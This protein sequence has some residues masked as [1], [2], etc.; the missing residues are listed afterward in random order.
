MKKIMLVGPDGTKTYIDAEE[1]KSFSEED[2]LEYLTQYFDHINEEKLTLMI[3]DQGAADEQI[4]MIPNIER[5]LFMSQLM[6]S[7][8]GQITSENIQIVRN[9]EGNDFH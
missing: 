5:Y 4:F 9:D 7:E 2:V 8:L 6:N 1:L 3:S